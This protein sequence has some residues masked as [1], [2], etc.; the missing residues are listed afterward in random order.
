MDTKKVISG[1]TETEIWDQI[2]ADLLSDP[3]LLQYQAE[4]NQSG[5]TIYLDID[6]DLG[7][8]FEGGFELT[9]FT[10]PLLKDTAFRFALHHEEFLDE[11]G[12]FFGMEDLITGYREFDSKV[13][14]KTNDLSKII[15]LFDD[16][17][18]RTVIQSLDVFRFYI[19]SES[20]K[21]K[22]V[23]EIEEAITDHLRLKEIYKV[24]HTV[25]KKITF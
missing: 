21:L 2:E 11:V 13:V 3:S 10:A 12:K 4:I 7:G 23:L 24:F 17:E 16:V 5:T 9:S 22:L 8:G 19:V 18:L 15:Q 25:L 20:N 1:Q 6:V 14:V